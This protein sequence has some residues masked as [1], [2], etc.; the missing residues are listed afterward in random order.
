[1]F[2]LSTVTFESTVQLPNCEFAEKKAVSAVPGTDAPPEVAAEL[3]DQFA[4][5]L[6]LPI[7]FLT[8]YLLAIY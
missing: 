8:Q 7:A 5:L 2:T 3:A 1:M 6:Q 4:V